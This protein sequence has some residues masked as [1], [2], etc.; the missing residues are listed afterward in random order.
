MASSKTIDG[1]TEAVTSGFSNFN[2]ESIVP[3]VEDF[4]GNLDQVPDALSDAIKK[5]ADRLDNE[6]PVNK[7]VSE[8]LREMIP[9]LGT[10]AERAREANAIFRQRHEQELEQHHNPRPGESA[11]NRRN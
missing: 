9:V 5:I 1:V 7:D 11:W 10:L 4:L 3:D 8:A 2:P 6:L